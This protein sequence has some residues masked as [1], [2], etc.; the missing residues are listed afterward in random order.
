MKWG[1]LER[2]LT[3]RVL[4]SITWKVETTNTAVIYTCFGRE[5]LKDSPCTVTVLIHQAHDKTCENICN[6]LPVDPCSDKHSNHLHFTTYM[7]EEG[8]L[9]FAFV[10]CE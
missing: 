8:E 10:D 7:F 1:E 9:D 5:S 2:V 3:L 6:L 4:F